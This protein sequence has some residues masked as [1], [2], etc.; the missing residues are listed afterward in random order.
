MSSNHHPVYSWVHTKVYT[1]NGYPSTD[2]TANNSH[3]KQE[4]SILTIKG[5]QNQS[6]KNSRWVL[7]NRKEEIQRSG[8]TSLK[9]AIK[10]VVWT[11]LTVSHLFSVTYWQNCR[12]ISMTMDVVITLWES[13]TKCQTINFIMNNIDSLPW[14]PIADHISSR[15]WG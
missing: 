6:K 8:R 11:P 12:E 2:I 4:I 1:I 13:L 9:W 10:L 15:Q 3:E 5:N 14:L 7:N